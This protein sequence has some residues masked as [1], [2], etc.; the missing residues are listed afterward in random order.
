MI[1]YQGLGRQKLG[2]ETEALKMFQ[3]LVDYGQ[4]HMDDNVRIDYFA[5]SLPDFLVFDE[6]LNRQNHIHCHYMMALGH[7]GLGDTIRAQAHFNTVLD[8]DI[9]HLGATLHKQFNYQSKGK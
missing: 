8:L 9:G 3:T 2:H 1:F 6:D 4:L 5:I 7:L